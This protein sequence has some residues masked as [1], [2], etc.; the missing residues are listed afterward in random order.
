V[1]FENEHVR[2]IEALASPGATAPMHTHPPGALVLLSKARMVRTLPGD[3]VMILDH[4]PG[5]AFWFEQ[6][7]HSWE[8]ESGLLHLVSVEIKSARP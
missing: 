2:V 5:Q 1:I 7:E 3:E 4:N 6:V 8:L